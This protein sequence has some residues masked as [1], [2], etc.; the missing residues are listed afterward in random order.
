MKCKDEIWEIS[1]LSMYWCRKGWN[2]HIKS[3][4][5]GQLMKLE[6]FGTSLNSIFPNCH[7]SQS[8]ELSQIHGFQVSIFLNLHGFTNCWTSSWDP[9]LSTSQPSSVLQLPQVWQIWVYPLSNF[10][11][12]I[13]CSTF[14]TASNF[15]NSLTF[16]KHHRI[17]H[18][19]GSKE[20]H[21]C[22]TRISNKMVSILQKPSFPPLKWLIRNLFTK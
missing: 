5:I 22:E 20:V 14:S 7:E 12:F 17:L 4:K 3:R 1:L 8:V 18:N 10:L 19:L 16:Q 6:K 15:Y 21:Y 2:L 9:S 11:K 13:H